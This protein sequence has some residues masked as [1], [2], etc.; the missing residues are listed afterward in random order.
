MKVLILANHLNFGGITAYIKNLCKSLHGKEGVEVMVASRGGDLEKDLKARGIL[1]LRIPLTTKSEASP[2]VFWSFLKL[3]KKIKSLEIDLIHANTRV[4]QVLAHLLSRATGVPVLTTCHGYFKR[5]LTRR[6]FPCWGKRI[7]AISDQV[8]EHLIHDFKVD[9]EIIRLIY[10]GVD[11]ERFSLYPKEDNSALKIGWGLNPDKKIIGHIG[12]LSSVKG[13]K[14]LVLAAALLLEARSDLQFLLIGDGPEKE[15][16]LALV[17]EKR[18]EGSFFIRPSVSD[19]SEALRMMDVF[20]MPSLQE[21]LGISIL[22]AQACGVAV[23]ASRVGGIPTIVA[24]ASTGLLVPAGDE[25]AL[26]FAISRLFSDEA[27]KRSV[28]QKARMQVQ[29]KFSLA[30]MAE[31]TRRLYKELCAC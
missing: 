30:I 22:E 14:F 27:L 10:N 15:N 9:P 21:G 25:R 16:L 12:R 23:V 24:D 7:I 5:R 2:K 29:E 6:L 31:K 18:L 13:Q 11:S 3:R 20:V 17:R 4:T 26:V 19:T 28:I 1:C 8:Q